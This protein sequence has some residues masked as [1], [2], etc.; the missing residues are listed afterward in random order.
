M[1]PESLPPPR[2]PPAQPE[3]PRLLGLDVPPRLSRHANDWLAAHASKPY[4]IYGAMRAYLNG[5]FVQ[6]DRIVSD[7]HDQTAAWGDAPRPEGSP[8]PIAHVH[9][10]ERYDLDLHFYLI[11][12]DKLNNLL[13]T[14]ERQWDRSDVREICGRIRG[15]LANASLARQY[16]EHLDRWI[17]KGGLRPRATGIGVDHLSF[18][19]QIPD[20]RGRQISR[21]VALGHSE[22]QQVVEAHAALA[23]LIEAWS[24]DPNMTVPAGLNDP[25]W[26]TV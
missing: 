5:A 17:D 13:E 9:A 8:V 2:V 11:C 19:Y 25:L 4:A 7:F 15:L 24:Q 1:D 22:L 16:F 12:W 3:S 21:S 10:V 18:H 23:E 14:F 20:G 6:Y 26:G